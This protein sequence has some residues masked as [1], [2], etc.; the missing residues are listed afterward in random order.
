MFR[1]SFSSESHSVDLLN[2]FPLEMITCSSMHR[3]YD[4]SLNFPH[5]SNF[6]RN[7]FHTFPYFPRKKP[8]K[9]PHWLQ[10]NHVMQ[11]KNYLPASQRFLYIE[12]VRFVKKASFLFSHV[13]KNMLTNR[14]SISTS[15]LVKSLH[16]VSEQLELS[17]CCK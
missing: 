1:S 2:T 16:E 8:T 10:N 14:F 12:C 17:K 9:K 3:L 13:C 15:C 4:A 5:L 6:D 7:L 11:G